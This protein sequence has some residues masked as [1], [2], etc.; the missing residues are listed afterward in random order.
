MCVSHSRS[1]VSFEMSDRRSVYVIRDGFD[2]V[3]EI[4]RILMYIVII[5]GI[6]VGLWYLSSIED[7]LEKIYKGLKPVI[8]CIAAEFCP[9]PIA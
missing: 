1:L 8:P 6:I 9:P 4:F 7:F 3:R 5:V 2:I